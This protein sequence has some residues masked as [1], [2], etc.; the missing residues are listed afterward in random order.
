MLAQ[1]SPADNNVIS[2]PSPPNQVNIA[3]ASSSLDFCRA[4]ENH[5]A[6]LQSIPSWHS[7]LYTTFIHE[8]HKIY[9]L[10]TVSSSYTLQTWSTY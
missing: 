4:A 6:F 8:I 7:I 2:N 9:T 5:Y 3:T 10:L 1:P